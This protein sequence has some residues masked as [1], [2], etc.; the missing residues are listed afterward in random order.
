MHY[1]PW[2]PQV[3]E[4]YELPVRITPNQNLLLLDIQPEWK[5]D[6]ITTL[7]APGLWP[8]LRPVQKPDELRFSI[9]ALQCLA[10]HLAMLQRRQSPA[11]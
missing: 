5:A 11:G 3:I 10:S 8:A 1:A 4:R 7:G 6:I 9:S 2:L